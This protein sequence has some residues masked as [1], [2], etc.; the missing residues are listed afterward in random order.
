M[1][2]GHTGMRRRL[3]S[4]EMRNEIMLA[5]ITE[6]RSYKCDLRLGNC[7]YFN[8]SAI[9]RGYYAFNLNFMPK[10]WVSY[11]VTLKRHPF[12]LF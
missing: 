10:M 7:K 5:P 8:Y 12:S 11:F 9:A 6:E 1:A 3:V 4:R 2:Q